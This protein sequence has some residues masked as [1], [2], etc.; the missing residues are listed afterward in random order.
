MATGFAAGVGEDD[1][2]V[3][4][5]LPEDLPAGSAR[6]RRTVG[7]EGDGYAAERFVPFRQRLEHGDALGANGQAVGGV[8]DVAAGNH[9]AARGQQG[10]P[11]LEF[12]IR[13]PRE[14]AGGTGVVHTTFHH[15][16]SG[17]NVITT[18]YSDWATNCPEYKVTAV[19]IR[20]TNRESKWQEDYAELQ[21]RQRIET[22]V[23]AE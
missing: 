20:L 16:E 10:R 18:D 2:E 5:E 9:L 11:D 1:L 6:R 7:I 21:K 22:V 13:C 4:A 14:E 3:A 19:E 23:A 17:A 8:L 12:R 15:P